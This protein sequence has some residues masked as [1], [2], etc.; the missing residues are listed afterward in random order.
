[1]PNSDFPVKQSSTLGQFWL[2]GQETTQV[3]GVLTVDGSEVCLE[4]SPGLTPFHTFSRLDAS[5]W[6][7]E[8]TQDA[9]DM[10]VLGSIPTSPSFVT[11]W[12]AITTQRRTVG[13]P[14]PLDP[15]SQ[16]A[17]QTLS[18]TWCV[19]GDHLPEPNTKLFGVRPDVTNLAEWAWIPAASQT[20]YPDD[21][22]RYD[23]H[24]NLRGKSLD[25]E[26]ADGTGYITLGPA[27][28][29]SSLGIRGFNVRT[30]SQLEIEL[31]SGW[32]MTEVVERALLPLADL[33][34]ILSGADCGVRSLEVWTAKW[35][36]VHGYNIAPSAPASA[37]KLLFSQPEV[38]ADFLA[39]WFD[40]H[41]RT[42]PVPQILAAAIRDEFPTV[43]A[44]ALSL[45][46]AVEALHRTLYPRARR[47]SEDEITKSLAALEISEI[48]TAVADTFASALRQHWHELSYPQRIR[49]LAEPVSTAVPDCIGRVGRWKEAVADQRISL[50]HGM[51]QG[52]LETDQ[53][54]RMSALN[55]SLQWML[56]LRLLLEAGIDAAVLK[57]ATSELDRYRA[58]RAQWRKAWPRI[59]MQ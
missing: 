4:V 17:A 47:F 46:T 8:T 45:A 49:A 29:M 23:W 3:T 44:Q 51:E 15:Q 31:V 16:P 5:R 40:L 11:V 57:T 35:C 10:V 32:S 54:L 28:S 55:R 37:G 42:T 30:S 56:T 50:A 7:M 18:A 27:A 22:L 52:R 59:F 20:F 21:R 2:P 48:P 58:D 39:R 43:E 13:M 53:I 12:D 26:L 34:T 19:V 1:M 36:S 33:M 9:T 41:Y 6:P 25:V 24:I 14:S 38:G